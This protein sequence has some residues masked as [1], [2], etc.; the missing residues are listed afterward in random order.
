FDAVEGVNALRKEGLLRLDEQ[1][2]L[3]DASAIRR[4]SRRA[5]V[6][7]LL[8]HRI[9]SLPP[10]SRLL[11]ECMACLGNSVGRDLLAAAVGERIEVLQEPLEPLLSGGLVVAEGP[12]GHEL[13]F[14]HDRLQQAARH[15][16]G[17]AR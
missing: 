6:V 8:A 4:F 17:E 11:L 2:W 12:D 16:M 5:D 9:E 3:W 7:D 1:G 15:T 10:Q 13:R 14:R